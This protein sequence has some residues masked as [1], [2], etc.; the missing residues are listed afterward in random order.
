MA[1]VLSGDCNL[2]IA[3]CKT[4]IEEVLGAQRGRSD[5]VAAL[6]GARTASLI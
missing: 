5:F 2:L 3:K 6:S 1:A 4:Q